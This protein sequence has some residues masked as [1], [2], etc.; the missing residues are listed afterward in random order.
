MENQVILIFQ[1][2]E[3]D[4]ANKIYLFKCFWEVKTLLIEL[5]KLKQI[6]MEQK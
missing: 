4:F 5:A 2:K 6:R 3:I 1:G